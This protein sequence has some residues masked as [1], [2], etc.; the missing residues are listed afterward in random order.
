MTST[1]SGGRAMGCGRRPSDEYGVVQ[2]NPS[3]K[4]IYVEFLGDASTDTTFS[5]VD[6]GG[7][8]SNCAP[9]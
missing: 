6:R 3:K 2:W 7:S 8:D 1:G 4:K 9:A 5:L